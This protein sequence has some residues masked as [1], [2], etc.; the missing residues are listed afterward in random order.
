MCTGR[1]SN[2]GPLGPKSD[3]LT[4][5][6]LRHLCVAEYISTAVLY[7]VGPCSSRPQLSRDHTGTRSEWPLGIYRHDRS[8]R[9]SEGKGKEQNCKQNEYGFYARKDATD[10]KIIS[11][12]HNPLKLR[13][14]NFN[15]K[16]LCFNPN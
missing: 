13:K 15:T 1:G 14:N 2:Q 3:A 16:S 9:H 10:T 7:T 12:A 11:Q 5:A 6:P 8:L 4:T